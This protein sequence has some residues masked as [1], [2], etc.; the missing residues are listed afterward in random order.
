[1][2]HL[3]FTARVISGSGRGTGLGVPTLNLDLRDV[4]PGLQDGVFACR[5]IAGGKSYAAAMHKGPRPTFG[6]I[7]SCEVHMIDELI[8][9]PPQSVTVEVVE[10]LRGIAKFLSSEALTS[11]MLEDIRQAKKIL[12]KK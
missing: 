11:Q 2:E 7:S 4:P 5:A 8:P 1:M 10:F 12:A 6:D 3:F 9:V